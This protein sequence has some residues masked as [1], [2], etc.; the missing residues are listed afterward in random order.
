[1]TAGSLQAQ[2]ET[3]EELARDPVL[4]VACALLILVSVAWVVTTRIIAREVRRAA[5]RRRR[6]SRRARPPRDIWGSPP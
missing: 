2:T 4:T 6:S 5:M 1:M 3:F